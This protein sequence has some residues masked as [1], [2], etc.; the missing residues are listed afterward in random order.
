MADIIGWLAFAVSFIGSTCLHHRLM[1]ELT[2]SSDNSDNI[3][4]NVT[5][6]HSKTSS[7]NYTSGNIQPSYRV[8][9]N[10]H[11]KAKRDLRGKR[12]AHANSE[13]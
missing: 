7:R 8:L 1:N 5:K 2:K 9:R 6:N 13:K 12:H 4:N 3:T 11:L 10:R